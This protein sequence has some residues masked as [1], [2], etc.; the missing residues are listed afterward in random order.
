MPIHSPLFLP[1]T[2]TRQSVAAAAHKPAA[3]AA[4]AVSIGAA[5]KKAVPPPPP[6]RAAPQPTEHTTLLRPTATSLSTTAAADREGW[7]LRVLWFVWLLNALQFVAAL[8]FAIQGPA[9]FHTLQF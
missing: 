6:P 4:V 8:Y 1:H 9:L 5:P 7:P 2:A 3:A